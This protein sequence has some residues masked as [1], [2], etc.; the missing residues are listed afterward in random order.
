MSST[1]TGFLAAF[2]SASFS[3]GQKA[4]LALHSEG[5]RGGRVAC[6]MVPPGL[7]L[8]PRA[9]RTSLVSSQMTSNDARSY[10]HMGCGSQDWFAVF[11]ARGTYKVCSISLLVYSS[12]VA[13][14][15]AGGTSAKRSCGHLCW[16]YDACF[17][18]S[19]LLTT[20]P[21]LEKMVEN[22]HSRLSTS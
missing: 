12:T 3:L 6:V 19:R 1:G 5:G 9:I 4:C 8:T 22:P 2:V 17:S 14:L 13:G 20:W 7:S 21:S 11:N 15:P 10:I 16:V 18:S